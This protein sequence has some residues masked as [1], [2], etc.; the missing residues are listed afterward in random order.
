[1]YAGSTAYAKLKEKRVNMQEGEN[2]IVTFLTG[3][4]KTI[5]LQDVEY[6]TSPDDKLIKY[7]KIAHHTV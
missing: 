4:K 7:I 3:K 1:M 6:S 2:K 5:S